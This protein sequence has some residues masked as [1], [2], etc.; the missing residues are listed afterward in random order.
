MYSCGKVI[1]RDTQRLTECTCE[2]YYNNR[3]RIRTSCIPLRLLFF[4]FIVLLERFITVKNFTT[5]TD[6]Y[7]GNAMHIGYIS[8]ESDIVY[9]VHDNKKIENVIH[10]YV[11]GHVLTFV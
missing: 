3:V 6:T 2:Q 9:V 1:P 11:C 7:Y 5:C 8:T 10:K 4:T